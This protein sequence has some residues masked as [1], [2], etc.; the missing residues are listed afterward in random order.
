MRSTRI[1]TPREKCFVCK[2]EPDNNHWKYFDVEG[3]EVPVCSKL[4]AVRGNFIPKPEYRVKRQ[5]AARPPG[6]QKSERK[7]LDFWESL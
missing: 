4:C 5:Y 7:N 2:L 1:K 6:H 3:Q